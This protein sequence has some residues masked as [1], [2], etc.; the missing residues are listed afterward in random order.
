[1]KPDSQKNRQ[2][3]EEFPFI[4]RSILSMAVEP[5]DDADML[6]VDSLAIHVEKA[7]GDL[8][9]RQADNVG[10]GE[11]SY[12]F[13]MKKERMEQVMRRGEFV[14]AV[15]ENDVVINQLFWPK[16]REEARGKRTPYAQGIFFV[17]D[18]TRNPDSKIGI[19]DKVKYLVWVKIEAWHIN[20]KLDDFDRPGARFGELCERSFDVTVYKKPE[21]GFHDL[22]RNSSKAENL[23]LDSR[24]LIE[25]F[26][27]KDEEIIA[28][29]GR[30]DE[31]CR[32]FQDEVYFDG[33]KDMR[34]HG[35]FRGASA[36]IGAT[37]L[38]CT[39]MCGYDRVMLE[40]DVCWISFQLRPEA[41]TMYVLGSGGTLPRIRN[42]VRTVIKAWREPGSELRK[43]FASDE[44]VS[45]M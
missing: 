10:L 33:M 34:E 35:E 17:H 8:M 36:R 9:Y 3:L 16:N 28:I 18:G 31:L 15:D 5:W 12:C 7:D 45:V 38:L 1:M 43:T 11:S 21:G 29:Q 41:T 2:L 42:L 6:R 39:E 14:L 23:Y 25:A 13:S 30:L 44:H 37:K 22:V 26:N 27:H 19:F 40:D 20:M 24:T 32:Q 4:G